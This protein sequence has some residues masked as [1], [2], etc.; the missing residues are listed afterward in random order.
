MHTHPNSCT[1]MKRK[2]VENVYVDVQRI[3]HKQYEDK[4]LNE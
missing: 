2:E 4:Q 1:V 3:E